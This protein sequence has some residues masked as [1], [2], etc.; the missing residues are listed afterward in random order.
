MDLVLVRPPVDEGKPGRLGVVGDD[1]ARAP[2]LG[3]R[4]ASG[5]ESG[6]DELGTRVGRVCSYAVDLETPIPEVLAADEA[7]RA[8]LVDGSEATGAS[9]PRQRRAT[10][11]RA[12]REE[13]LE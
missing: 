1:E 10:R 6:R 9:W 7:D 13:R 5:V 12:A 2:A 3:Q 4:L 11:E 8:G